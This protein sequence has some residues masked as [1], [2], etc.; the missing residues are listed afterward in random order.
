VGKKLVDLNIEPLED[1]YF[2]WA[3]YVFIS[4]M[5]MQKTSAIR[6]INRCKELGTKVVAGG[7][8]FTEHYE[9]F[10]NVDHLVLGEAEATLPPFLKDLENG[11]PEHIYMPDRWPDLR[12]APP[13]TWELVDLKNTMI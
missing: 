11:N 12:E 5:D 7:S 8:F 2:Q 13:P 1:K 10:E 3:D 6:I 4:A 9:D